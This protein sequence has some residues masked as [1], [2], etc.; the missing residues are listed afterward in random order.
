M[1]QDTSFADYRS[2]NPFSGLSDPV[3]NHAILARS[4]YEEPVLNTVTTL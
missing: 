1:E 4:N 2:E 3:F